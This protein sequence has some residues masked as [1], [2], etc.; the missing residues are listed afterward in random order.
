LL[1]S[2]GLMEATGYPLFSGVS[3]V[4]DLGTADGGALFGASPQWFWRLILAVG[5]VA[6]YLVAIRIALARLE[7]RLSGEGAVR[8]TVA[9][10]AASISY[11]TGAATYLVIGIFNPYGWT[12]LLLSVLPSSLGGTSGLLWM[13]HYAPPAR[14]ASGPG[15]YFARQ[16]G[17]IIAGALAT[18]IYALIFARTL[19]FTP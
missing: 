7:P 13:F 9:R 4:G 15:L 11:F 18:V 2:I 19:R 8:L 17:W 12:I 6:A 16:K 10:R 3:G 14:T 5:G 1:G